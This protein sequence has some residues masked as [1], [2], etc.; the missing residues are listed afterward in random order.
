MAPESQVAHIASDE[1]AP[2]TPTLTPE[3]PPHHI[4]TIDLSWYSLP[5]VVSME[6]DNVKK[7]AISVSGGFRAG[8]V[9]EP[10]AH[11]GIGAGGLLTGAQVV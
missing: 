3:P 11:G 2:H 1:R 10:L 4:T 7:W 5:L 8:N 9:R 6:H